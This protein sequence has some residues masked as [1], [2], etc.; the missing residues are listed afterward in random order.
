MTADERESLEDVARVTA[1]LDQPAALESSTT[2]GELVAPDETDF[3]GDVEETMVYE[4][5]RE[6]VERLPGLQRDVL[7]LRFGFGGDSP[8][9]L[10]STAERLGVGVRRV[11]RAEEEALAALSG[12]P[13]VLG[14][15]EAA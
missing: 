8:A 10:Q 15:H 7:R 12:D 6:A 11:R 2:L 14:V 4:Q 9:S 3:A 5:V 1:S 13:N